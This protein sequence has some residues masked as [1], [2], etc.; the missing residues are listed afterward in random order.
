LV[1]DFIGGERADGFH[2][3]L[4]DAIATLRGQIENDLHKQLIVLTC[5]LGHSVAIAFAVL[6][7]SE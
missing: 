5:V 4:A 7:F 2:R 6:V 1:V 3:T